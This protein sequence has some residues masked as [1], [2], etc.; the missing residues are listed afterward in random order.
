MITET[1]PY[2]GGPPVSVFVPDMPVEAIV[3][4]A[5]GQNVATWGADLIGSVSGPAASAVADDFAAGLS[6]CGR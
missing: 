2:G 3:F 4:A 1:L 6:R 5:D